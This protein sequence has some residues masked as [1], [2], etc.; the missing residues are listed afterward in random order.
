MCDQKIICSER[1]CDASYKLVSFY[2]NQD[3]A[4]HKIP[5][6]QHLKFIPQEVFYKNFKCRSSQQVGGK[7]GFFFF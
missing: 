4:C 5:E 3:S 1:F 6:K 2:L 7:R